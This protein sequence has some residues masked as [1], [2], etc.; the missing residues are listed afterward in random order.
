MLLKQWP[1]Y[2]VWTDDHKGG[3]VINL[4]NRPCMAGKV[5]EYCQC[6]ID[7]HLFRSSHNKHLRQTLG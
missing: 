1:N 7:V 5:F 4:V 6:I 3:V 2:S